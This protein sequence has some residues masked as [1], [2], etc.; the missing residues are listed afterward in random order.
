MKTKSLAGKTE[1]GAKTIF[2]K[3]NYFAL[4]HT[5]CVCYMFVII[6]FINGLLEKNE[7]TFI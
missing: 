1:I 7:F 4:P 3:E 5:L 2:L 6:A